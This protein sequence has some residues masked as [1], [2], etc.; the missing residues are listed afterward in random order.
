MSS[1]KINNE[2]N[3]S[4]S[5]DKSSLQIGNFLSFGKPNEDI[6]KNAA[7]VNAFELKSLNPSAE[8][9]EKSRRTF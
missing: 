1:E 9:K 7:P 5:V 4:D 6:N 8:K 2:I 3:G